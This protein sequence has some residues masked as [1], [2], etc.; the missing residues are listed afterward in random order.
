MECL[1]FILPALLFAAAGVFLALRRRKRRKPPPDPS[2]PL[3]ED[4][5]R[6]QKE[7]LKSLGYLG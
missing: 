3:S 6:E 1:I 4:E 7:K 5:M 2:R